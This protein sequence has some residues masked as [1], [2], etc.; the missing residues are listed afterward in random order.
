LTVTAISTYTVAYYGK[1]V[2]RGRGNRAPNAV[3][4]EHL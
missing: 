2:N 4:P 3:E 1:L